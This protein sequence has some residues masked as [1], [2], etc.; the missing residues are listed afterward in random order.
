MTAGGEA[1][2]LL[3]TDPS[4]D[5]A[6]IHDRQMVVLECSDRS[7]WL[8]QTGNVA[9]GSSECGT[10]VI[11]SVGQVQQQFRSISPPSAAVHAGKSS[12]VQSRKPRQHSSGLL[13]VRVEIPQLATK[14]IAWPENVA[15]EK[16]EDG[17]YRHRRTDRCKAASPSYAP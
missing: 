3:T 13:S 1:F 7:A 8:E 4:P 10:T 11:K 16:E 12:W 15:F 14:G 2:T 6:P 17:P 5:I 9:S